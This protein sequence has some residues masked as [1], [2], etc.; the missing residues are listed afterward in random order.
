M[1]NPNIFIYSQECCS[2]VY[3]YYIGV[4][5]KYTPFILN[6]KIWSIHCSV[7][8][9]RGLVFWCTAWKKCSKQ[10]HLQH[11]YINIEKVTIFKV[12][13]VAQNDKPTENYSPNSAASLFYFY[14]TVFSVGCFGFLQL[15]LLS[16]LQFLD[17]A[18]SCFQ[19]EGFNKSAVRYLPSA[20]QQTGKTS[21]Q[22]LSIKQKPN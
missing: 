9:I 5:K 8:C 11:S 21:K 20:E 13:V 10:Q 4:E 6:I 18:G 19:W 22:T 15:S 3:V 1:I 16:V 7:C 12:N 2:V 17:A 14:S